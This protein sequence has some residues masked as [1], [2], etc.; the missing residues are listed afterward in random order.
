MYWE[1]LRRWRASNKALVRSYEARCRAKYKANLKAA[2]AS[3]ASGKKEADLSEPQQ[4][5]VAR[6]AAETS[7]ETA[8]AVDRKAA[9]H[10][11]KAAEK[12][13]V[14]D[15]EL[16]PAE[17]KAKKL[18]E[19][20]KQKRAHQDRVVAEAEAALAAGIPLTDTQQKE[21]ERRETRKRNNRERN[22]R[23]RAKG[24]K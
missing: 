4:R 8:R 10:Q 15:S 12:R 23:T 18:R 5:A 9:R 13:G 20:G 22:R 19:Q 7:R 2:K 14:S 21:L 11:L 24:K 6:R 17:A 16:T 3:L 1:T